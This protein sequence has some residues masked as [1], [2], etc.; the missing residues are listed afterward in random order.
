MF[1]RPLGKF[2]GIFRAA[3]GT[4]QTR[5][6]EQTATRPL[7]F[8]R[9]AQ[10]SFQG[11][12]HGPGALRIHLANMGQGSGHA[13]SLE[14]LRGGGLGKGAGVGIAELLAHGGLGQQLG[15]GNQ[16]AQAQAGRQHFAERAAMRQQVAAAGHGVSQ[17]QQRGRRGLTEV[18]VAIGVVFH[19][20]RVVFDGEF[21]HP[22][23][24]LQAQHDTA[25]V[26]E[27][28]N[29]V[30]KFGLVLGDEFFELIGLHAM[31]IDGRADQLCA[32]QPEALDGGQKGRAF[33]NDLVA[34]RNHGFAEQVKRLLAAGGHDELLG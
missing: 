4:R 10:F 34:G 24:P 25:G 7:K 18:E 21:Q 14:V 15:L 22:L 9:I 8:N 28:G 26:A 12:T 2:A 30:D 27:G 20:Q 3:I 19:H 23:A 11:I 13:A 32:I 6:E 5:P 33:D 31:G 1:N 17:G 16:P 29:Q